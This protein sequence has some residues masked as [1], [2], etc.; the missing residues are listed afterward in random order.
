MRT[1]QQKLAEVAADTETAIASSSNAA[2]G[3]KKRDTKLKISAI[4]IQSLMCVKS[5][6][7]GFEMESWSAVYYWGL[8]GISSAASQWKTTNFKPSSSCTTLTSLK[9]RMQM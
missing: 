7:F 3:G 4:N 2:G 9:A 6:R 8:P 1:Y 5:W